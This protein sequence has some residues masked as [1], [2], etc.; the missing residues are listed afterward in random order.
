MAQVYRAKQEIGDLNSRSPAQLLPLIAKHSDFLI[1]A[2]CKAKITGQ[3]W[4]V[5]R[6]GEVVLSNGDKKGDSRE[7]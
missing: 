4:P 3:L 5:R 2:L 1:I 6:F 7:D